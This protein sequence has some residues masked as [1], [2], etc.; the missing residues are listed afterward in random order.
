[1]RKPAKYLSLRRPKLRQSWN[2]HNLYNL[3]RMTGEE[4]FLDSRKTFFQQKW[5]AKSRTR[6]YHGEHVPEKKWKRIFSRRLSAAV[7]MPPRYLAI[8]DGSEQAAGRGSGLTTGQT[9]AADYWERPVAASTA[10]PAHRRV[11]TGIRAVNQMIEEPLSAVTPLMQMTF[12]PLERRL[13]T[14][15]FRALFATSVR[16]ARQFVVHG[17]VKVNGKKITFP[18]YALNPGDMFQVD[19][20]KV[21]YATGAPK[22]PGLKARVLGILKKNEDK[23]QK[24]EEKFLSSK[25][26][27]KSGAESEA[28]ASSETPAEEATEEAKAQKEKSR[29]EG[30]EKTETLSAEDALDLRKL[31]LECALLEAKQV[32]RDK[33]EDRDPEWRAMR[34]RSFKDRAGYVLSTSGTRNLEVDELINELQLEMKTLN[35]LRSDEQSSSDEEDSSDKKAKNESSADRQNRRRAL[36]D[37]ALE[38]DGVKKGLRKE[39][40]KTIGD[41]D[42]S[43]KE[44]RDLGRILKRDAENPVDETKAYNTPWAPRPYMKPFVFVP[45]YLEV[46]HKICAAV[47][48]RHPVARRG[49]GEVPTP[50]SFLTNQLAHNWYVERG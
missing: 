4:T 9:S 13:D 49:A 11:A 39:L 40:M 30:S 29:S 48:L 22:T 27:V 32:I 1:M 12:A 8:H 20:D 37:R 10:P 44:M 5:S 36:V 14:A 16:Q 43:T 34:L 35:M 7:D 21:L 50:F 41:E 25:K 17:A 42:L 26:A 18:S 24:M 46:N 6:G 15:V 33:V 45:R 19:A 3:S 2:I 23:Y 38:M 47:Y 31:R 28:V